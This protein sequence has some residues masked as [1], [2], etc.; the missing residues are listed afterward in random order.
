[1]YL[2]TRKNCLAK[3][4]IYMRKQFGKL[5]HFFP[6]TYLLPSEMNELKTDMND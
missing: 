1:M 3:N 2:L 4:L 5:Y 6:K